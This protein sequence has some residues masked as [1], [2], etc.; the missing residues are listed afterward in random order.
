[1]T[2]YLT[3]RRSIIRGF[4]AAAVAIAATASAQAQSTWTGNAN[5]T[6]SDAGNW[7]NG[8]PSTTTGTAVFTS[9]ASQTTVTNGIRIDFQRLVFQSGALAYTIGPGVGINGNGSITVE[10]GVSTNQTINGNVRNQGTTTSTI[11]NNGTG[12]LNFPGQIFSGGAWTVTFDGPGNITARRIDQQDSAGVFSIVKNGAGTLT[13]TTGQPA[14]AAAS[15]GHYTGSTTINGGVLQLG[16]AN[17]MGG[18]TTGTGAITFGGGTLRYS[19]NTAF[20]FAP[21]IVSSTAA[22]SIDTAGRNVEFSALAASNTGG[23]T[24][25][26]SGTLS[27]VGANQYTGGT[28]IS[29]G[30]LVI[31]N[32][33]A[34]GSILGN[35]VNN[36]ALVFSR[37]DAVTFGGAVSGSGTV[38]KQGAGLLTFTGNNSYAGATAVDVGGLLVNGANSGSGLVTVANAAR[39]GG[40]GSLAGGLTIAAGGLFAFNPADPTL[41]VSGAVSLDNSFGIASLVNPDGS[42]ITWSSVNDGSYSLIGL[43]S[44]LFSGISNFGAGNAADIGTGRTAYFTNTTESG[45]LSLVVVPEPGTFTLAGLGLAA[46]AAAWARRRSR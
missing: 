16:D 32:G 13:L 24:K 17:S 15:Q 36:A 3:T 40:T 44:S 30:T 12:L 34:Q 18:S 33:A 6:W 28:T 1:M 45:G 22:I 10:S 23:L 14:A 11:T 37:S 25:S 9:S 29:G 46:A 42:A 39:I 35:V 21:R 43:T 41:D 19:A 2:T 26:G 20:N 5:S 27:L 38:A 4:A 8:V 7:S 31:G